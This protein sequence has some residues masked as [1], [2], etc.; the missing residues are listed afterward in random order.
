MFKTKNTIEL[1]TLIESVIK[2]KFLYFQ[3]KL[4]NMEIIEKNGITIINSNEFTDMFNTIYCQ[5]SV[6]I[7]QINDA[8]NFF[9]NKNLPF[10]WWMGFE[11]ESTKLS[12]ML[13][14]CSLQ[15]TE[16][17]LLMAIDLCDFAASNY[18]QDLIFTR[19]TDS[20]KLND[21][22]NIITNIMPNE[23]SAIRHFFE[24]SSEMIL[25]SDC[26]EYYV[27]Y[28]NNQPISTLSL[29]YFQGVASI[30]DVIVLPENRG[31]K[32]A[33]TMVVESLKIASNKQCSIVAL[34]ATNDAKNVYEKLGFNSLKPM[35]VY[36][37]N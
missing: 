33:S 26:I 3:G 21:L 11:N 23:S 2:K 27:G 10:S 35:W 25:K 29:F 36:N 1:L 5:G 17:E 13:E 37:L 9:S 16:N 15:K 8:I 20:Q 30:F 22:V 28:H 19:V 4:A 24:R 31:M 7:S 6:N 18:Q 34:T 32:I 14:Q 12:S